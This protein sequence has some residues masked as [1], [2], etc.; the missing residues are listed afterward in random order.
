MKS[1]TT[2]RRGS[3][4]TKS[5]RVEHRG[6]GNGNAAHAIETHETHDEQLKGQ[7][8]IL[9]LL[10]PPDGRLQELDKKI[11]LAALIAFKKGDF[12]ARLPVDLEGMDG[13]I[14]DAFNEVIELNQRLST[15]LERLSRVVGKE[16][17]I[18]QRATMGSVTGA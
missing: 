3:N 11:L 5:N 10:T 2:T 15:E 8:S 4:T 6:N 13:K 16:G 17:K 9:S 7:P 1:K 18:S 14:A 12:S